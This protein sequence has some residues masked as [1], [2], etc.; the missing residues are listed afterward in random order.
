MTVKKIILI[1]LFVNLTNCGFESIYSEGNRTEYSVSKIILEGEKNTNRK[2]VSSLNLNEDKNSPYKI[3][4]ISEKTNLTTAKDQY[5][6][7][8]IYELTITTKFF[9]IRDEQVIKENIFIESFSYNKSGNNFEL[10]QYQ[11]NIEIDLINRIANKIIV[12]LNT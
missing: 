2:V 6:N 11:K 4:L 5:G 3:K 7:P 1:L 12:F 10:M 8:S 9:F